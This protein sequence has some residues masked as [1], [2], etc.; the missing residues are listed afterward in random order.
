MSLDIPASSKI[1]SYIVSLT[2]DYPRNF[3]GQEETFQKASELVSRF[4][5]EPVFGQFQ[6]QDTQFKEEST[7]RKVQVTVTRYLGKFHRDHTYSAWYDLGSLTSC[8][9]RIKLDVLTKQPRGTSFTFAYKRG[10]SEGTTDFIYIEDLE[11]YAKERYRGVPIKLMQLA[12]EVSEQHGFGGH[13]VAHVPYDAPGFYRKRHF[14]TG[15]KNKD[16][17]IDVSVRDAKKRGMKPLLA[18]FSGHMRLDA[19]GYGIY[20][21]MIRNEPVL[22]RSSVIETSSLQLSPVPIE[23]F[24]PNQTEIRVDKLVNEGKRHKLNGEKKS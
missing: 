15:D 19:N 18:D 22:T 23:E 4:A 8:I 2:G 5:L 3:P 7:G 21:E 1:S 6:I 24:L 14:T 11:S 17:A 10:V 12:V 16:S 9:A 13:V 20:R